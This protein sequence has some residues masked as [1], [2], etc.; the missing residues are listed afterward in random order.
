M[1]KI[2]QL[3]KND[4][5]NHDE[6]EKL[7]KLVTQACEHASNNCKKTLKYTKGREIYQ[8]GAN[9]RTEESE[10]YLQVH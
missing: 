7:D 8:Y 1:S 5:P 4:L 9:T 10:K 3:R 2:N 6:A